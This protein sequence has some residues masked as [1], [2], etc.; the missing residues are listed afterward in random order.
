M[1]ETQGT[2]GGESGESGGWKERRRKRRRRE[3]E[4]KIVVCVFLFTF[5]GLFTVICVFCWP[6]QFPKSKEFSVL[7]VSP[8]LVHF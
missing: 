2:T 6:S 8:E 1:F 4:E 3:K 7:I 5:T